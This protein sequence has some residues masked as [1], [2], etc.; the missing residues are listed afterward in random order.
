MA[1]RRPGDKPLYEPMM[2]QLPMHIC[3]TRP[4]WVNHN[5]DLPWTLWYLNYRLLYSWGNGLL[6]VWC[7]VIACAIADLFTMG[8]L[9]NTSQSEHDVF[10][11]KVYL[12]MSS[13]EYR[14]FCSGPN[15]SNCLLEQ[16]VWRA[17]YIFPLL[18]CHVL[19]SRAWTVFQQ[20]VKINNTD[21]IQESFIRAIQQG[22]WITL[23]KFS[24]Y[25]KHLIVIT[26]TYYLLLSAC[27][28]Q[29][30]KEIGSPPATRQTLVCLCCRHSLGGLYRGSRRQRDSTRLYIQLDTGSKVPYGI[31]EWGI[32]FYLFVMLCGH[33]D[34]NTRLVENL[35]LPRG[36]SWLYPLTFN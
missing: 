27:P 35:W 4:Q 25:E 6:P 34:K 20:F 12:K 13:A 11:K 2:V 1:W 22:Q 7:K 14:Q 24:W 29:N 26:S 3:V 5:R 16:P 18:W 28:R 36:I 15:V 30:L 23:T 31:R 33:F 10:A 19:K 8:L 32:S 9:T 21:N 17:D